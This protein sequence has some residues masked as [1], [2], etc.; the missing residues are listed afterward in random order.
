MPRRTLTLLLVLLLSGCAESRP[1]PASFTPPPLPPASPQVV[2]IP[3]A[4]QDFMSCVPYAREVTGVE[5]FGDAWT[6]WDGAE[7][8]YARGSAPEVAGILVFKR[9]D[10]LQSGHV[11]VVTQVISLRE[12]LVTHANWAFADKK[13]GQV[14]HDVPIVDVSPNNDWSEIRVWNGGS[15]GRIYPAHGFIYPRGSGE[16]A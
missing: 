5:L 13:R 9:S 12:V 2:L 14:D 4:P 7:D 10:R 3:P 8:Q 6:W 1:T 16:S 11:A 15:Y